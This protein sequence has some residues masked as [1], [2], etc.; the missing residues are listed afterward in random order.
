MTRTKHIGLI[1][2]PKVEA[3]VIDIIS[4]LKKQGHEYFTARDISVCCNMNAMRTSAYLKMHPEK[5]SYDRKL[6]EWKIL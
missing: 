5:V 3:K 6:G 1:H 2:H 4:S